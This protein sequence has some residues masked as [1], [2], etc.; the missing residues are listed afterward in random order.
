MISKITF[1]RIVGVVANLFAI[2]FVYEGAAAQQSA[3]ELIVDGPIETV[4]SWKRDA[5]A[6]WDYPDASIRA[7]KLK[8]GGVRAFASSADNFVL[9][10][11]SLDDLKNTCHSAFRENH[12]G[13]PSIYDDFGWIASTW[14]PDGVRVA[15]LIHS[16][17]HALDHPGQCTAN[18]SNGCWYTVQTMG[19]SFDG[20]NTFARAKIPEIAAAPGVT[21]EVGQGTPRGF[22]NPSNLVEYKGFYY[23]LAYTFGY[24]EQKAGACLFRNV[25]VFDAAGWRAFDGSGFNLQPQ[26]PYRSRGPIPSCKPVGPFVNAVGSITRDERSGVLIATAQLG[27]SEKYKGG[28]VAYATSI[29]MIHWTSFKTLVENSSMWSGDCQ[30][31]F[32]YASLIDPDTDAINYDVIGTSAYIYMTRFNLT[33][34]KIGADRDLVRFRVRVNN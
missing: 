27:P 24:G 20:G 1:T 7:F 17:Y 14:T 11:K 16:E 15:A 33:E 29:D 9:A 34:C 4:L 25:D 22:V 3:V 5:C 21:E 30:V 6:R 32:A 10:G 8:D 26:D 13:N 2:I 19:Y 31:R 18:T 28:R 12:S 23:F